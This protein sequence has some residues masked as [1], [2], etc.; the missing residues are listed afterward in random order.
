VT[1]AVWIALAGLA[2]AILGHFG[3]WVYSFATQAERARQMADR[4]KAL[5]AAPKDDCA[6]QLAAMTATLVAM[7]KRLDS[8]EAGIAARLSNLETRLDAA[9]KHSAPAPRRRAA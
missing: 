8:M 7:E 2:L 5:E 1:P 6:V 9:I 4:I 3:A